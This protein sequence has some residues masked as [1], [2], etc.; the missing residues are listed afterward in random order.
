MPASSLA[1]QLG[2]I[3]EQHVASAESNR[4]SLLYTYKQVKVLDVETIF[5][6]SQNGLLELAQLNPAFSE[7][8]ENLF[9][10]TSKSDLSKSFVRFA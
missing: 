7:F 3:R 9:H 4:P 6:I 1:K 10:E 8:Q 2:Q 5:A